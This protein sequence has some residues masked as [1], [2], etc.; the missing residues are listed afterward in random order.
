MIPITLKFLQGLRMPY[1]TLTYTLHVYKLNV[2]PVDSSSLFL[3]N[4]V[5]TVLLGEYTLFSCANLYYPPLPGYV[6]ILNNIC[7]TLT[8]L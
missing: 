6:H 4:Q 5:V 3:D 1:H 2:W 7:S 8:C